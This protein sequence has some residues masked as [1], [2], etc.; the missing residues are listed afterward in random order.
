MEQIQRR[1]LF[2]VDNN[3]VANEDKAKE[4]FSALK[5][6]H[7]RWTAQASISIADNPEL[8]KAAADAGCY[9]LLIGIES[10]TDRGLANYKKSKN[11]FSA[12]KNSIHILK[13]NGIAVLAHM[14]FGNDFETKESMAETLERLFELD[15]ASATLGILVPYPG[16]EFTKRLETENRITTH[17][18]NLY[19]I[20][21]LVFNPLNFSKSEFVREVQSL[22]EQYFSYWNIFV[23]TIRYKNPVV[24][25]FNLASRSHN[26]IR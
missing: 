18:W 17:D 21:H 5:P 25:G 12:L 19:D 10:I 4:L 1:R 15:V 20:H 23:R 22:R 6:L 3:I 26:R 14:V 13:D 7:K 9:G 11:D 24:F 2:F 8:T 16:T